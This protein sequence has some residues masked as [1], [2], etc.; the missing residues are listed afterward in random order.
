[1]GGADLGNLADCESRGIAVCITAYLM[2]VT[3]RRCSI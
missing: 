3:A 2:P 1:V